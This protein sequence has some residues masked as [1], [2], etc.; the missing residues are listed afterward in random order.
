MTAYILFLVNR[1]FRVSGNVVANRSCFACG[2]QC[3]GRLGSK[4]VG[5]VG[6]R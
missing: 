5:Y 2:V 6:A 4:P 1:A 3:I